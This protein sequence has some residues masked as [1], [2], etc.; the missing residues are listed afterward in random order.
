MGAGG[1]EVRKLYHRFSVAILSAALLA[2]AVAQRTGFKM[3][4]Y[5]LGHK[6]YLMIL[7]SVLGSIPINSI[8]YAIMVYK[9]GG[10]LPQYRTPRYFRDYWVIA[11]LNI[12]NGLGIMWANPFVAGYQQA[13]ISSMAIP[14]TMCLSCI[15]FGSRYSFAAVAGVT[16]IISGV[17]K[18]SLG[19]VPVSGGAFTPTSE[20]WTGVFVLSQVPLS[21]ASVYQEYAFQKS[22]NMLHYVHYVTLFLLLD[23]LVCMPLDTTSFGDASSFADFYHSFVEYSSCVLGLD[24]SPE[25]KTAGAALACYIVCMNVNNLLQALLIKSAGATW[26]M[27]VVSLGTPLGALAFS[28]PSIV[29]EEHVEALDPG[30]YVATALVTIGVMVYRVGSVQ[31]APKIAEPECPD[32]YISLED[33]GADVEYTNASTRE[34]ATQTDVSVAPTRMQA[35]QVLAAFLECEAYGPPR[36]AVVAAG[37]GLF[38]S[39]Y[40]NASGNPFSLFEEK[41]FAEE[42]RSRGREDYDSGQRARSADGF[43]ARAYS[44][45]AGTRPS[46]APST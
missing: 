10:V 13:L 21:A 41:T 14:L 12:F 18:V 33:G 27:V 2:C 25:C 45:E 30:I 34:V 20:I 42:R 5:T 35:A 32:G 15:C 31:S 46:R 19:G 3:A 39:E 22:L 37:I 4:G 23:L 36:P 6:P 16:L 29:G 26:S 11:T 28:C 8:A 24:G 44:A 43:R 7:L 1:D 38:N 17:L 9:T 40:T